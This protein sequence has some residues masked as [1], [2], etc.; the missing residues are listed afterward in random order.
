MVSQ[1]VKERVP[2][3]GSA[4]IHSIVCYFQIKLTKTLRKLFKVLVSR[5]LQGKI[6]LDRVFDV[7]SP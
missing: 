1:N 5:V 4:K 6:F 3:V 7:I 2:F